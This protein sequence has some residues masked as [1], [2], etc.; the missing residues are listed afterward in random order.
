MNIVILDWA[1]VTLGDI[2]PDI[3]NQLGNV[4]TYDLTPPELASER[5]GNAEAVLCN[6]TPITRGVLDKC[7]NL[8]YIGLFATGYNNIDINAATEKGITVC[9]AGSYSTN[10]V[11]Q[12]VFAHI[13]AHYN[14]VSVYDNDVKNDKWISSPIF[15]YFPY[16]ITELSG[17]TLAIVGFGSIGKAVAKIGR[18]FDMN[19]VITSRTKPADCEYQYVS[20]NEAFEL[21]DIITFHCPLTEQTKNLVCLDKLKKMKKTAILINTARGGIVVEEDL[22]YAL[23]NDIIA[24]AGLDVLETEPMTLDTP[25]RNAKN[26]IITPHVAWAAQETRNKLVEIVTD[27]LKSFIKGNIKN[28]VN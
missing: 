28:K 15:S 22:A 18:A 6:K 21:A 3:F 5:I 7:P 2:S 12:M 17:K 10:A 19:V 11:A 16:P 8:K 23:N 4:K 26:C 24:G 20:I 1:T 25:L 27:N 9:N 14:K 13:L